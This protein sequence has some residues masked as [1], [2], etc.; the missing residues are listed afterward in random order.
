M[1]SAKLQALDRGT[2]KTTLHEDSRALTVGEVL[3][4]WRENESFCR[5]FTSTMVAS[6]FEAF[7]WETPAITKATL[8]HPFEFVLVS[9][10]SLNDLRPE[11]NAFSEHFKAHPT[12]QIVTFTNLGRDATLVVPAPLA[13]ASCYTHLASFLR[14]APEKQTSALWQNVYAALAS[15]TSN[16]PV[17]VSTAGMG[18]SWLHVRLD[19]RPKYYRHGPYRNFA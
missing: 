15:R 11:P 14:R 13:E 6:E 4:L 17:W 1:W 2:T 5:F 19:S 12:A 10:P 9:A 16:V 8:N 18:V 3:E 7:F